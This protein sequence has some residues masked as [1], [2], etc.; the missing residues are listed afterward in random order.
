MDS[1][2]L[3]QLHTPPPSPLFVSDD[4]KR[5]L[6]FVLML[7]VL[8]G[9][10]VSC[11]ALGRHKPRTP[12]AHLR[13]PFSFYPS[14]STLLDICRT[15]CDGGFRSDDTAR[16]SEVY[17]GSHAWSETHEAPTQIPR[18]ITEDEHKSL[19]HGAYHTIGVSQRRAA[20]ACM[21]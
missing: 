19:M 5:T 1:T 16:I 10:I 15:A 7:I 6:V 3:G 11:T 18:G 2:T 20:G 14:R 4:Q 17:Q 21:H 13:L 12:T 8:H 9:R